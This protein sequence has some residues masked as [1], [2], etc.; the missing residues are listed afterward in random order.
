MEP[1]VTERRRASRTRSALPRLEP[2]EA[3]LPSRMSRS[4]RRSSFCD[5]S[6]TVPPWIRIDAMLSTSDKVMHW[7]GKPRTAHLPRIACFAHES[8]PAT[9]PSTERRCEDR[10]IRK[11]HDDAPFRRPHLANRQRAHPD[12]KDR[13]ECQNDSNQKPRMS[14]SRH[15]N[16][17]YSLACD[18]RYNTAIRIAKPL[19]TCDRI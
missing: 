10:D 17:C 9:S 5:G 2:T 3:I 11:R 15:N 4:A 8:L 12:R 16:S 18:T 13:E 6:R 14:A 19:V 7:I 1:G